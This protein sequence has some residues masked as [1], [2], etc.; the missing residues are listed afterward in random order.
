[1]KAKNP[2]RVSDQVGLPWFTYHPDPLKTGSVEASEARCVCCGRE[3]GYIYVAP[4]YAA[5]KLTSQLCPWCIADGSAAERFGATYSD[6][7][8]LIQ[9]GVPEAVIEEVTQRTP[10]FHSWQGEDWKACCGDACEFHG[11]ASRAHLLALDASALEHFLS[12]THWTPEQWTEFVSDV[13]EPGSSPAIYHFACR[14]CPKT[15]YGWETD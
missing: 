12:L 10:G 4:V 14:K 9:A 5:E 7:H 6:G 2:A 3:R 15:K 13:Y 11:Q 8:S 1:M